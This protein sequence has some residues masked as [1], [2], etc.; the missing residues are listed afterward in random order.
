MIEFDDYESESEESDVESDAET[1]AREYKSIETAESRQSA[2]AAARAAAG[3]D[4]NAVEMSNLQDVILGD[5][6]YVSDMTE[7]DPPLTANAR[8]VHREIGGAPVKPKLYAR[9]K[10][11]AA[12]L[13]S[14]LTLV[15]TMPISIA[16]LV[17]GNQRRREEEA[18]DPPPE[19]SELPEEFKKLISEKADE[20]SKKPITEAFGLIAKLVRGI[21]F[22]LQAQ[23]FMMGELKRLAK[24]PDG[25]PKE[26]EPG[27]QK[28]LASSLI[29]AYTSGSVPKSAALYDAVPSLRMGNPARELTVHEGADVADL[30]IC[31]IITL[32]RGQ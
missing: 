14:A 21:T 5:S 19:T 7:S 18:T 15:L 24:Q 16:A 32:S 29:D 25:F 27:V 12:I 23:G 31:Q 8:A 11:W 2:A 28:G 6:E 4:R 1:I 20:W 3:L 13:P 26:W 10:F 9:W 22:S 17:L 30:A